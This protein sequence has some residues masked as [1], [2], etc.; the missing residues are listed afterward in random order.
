VN[1]GAWMLLGTFAFQPGQNHRVVLTDDGD[2]FVIADA[3]KLVRAPAAAPPAEEVVV[4]NAAAT[5]VGTWTATDYTLDGPFRDADWIYHAAGTGTA[6]ASFA[7]ALP[8]AGTYRVYA[9]WTQRA[10]RASNAPFTVHHAGGSTTVRVNQ[11]VNGG[12]WVLLGAFDMA[13]GQNHRVVLTDDANGFVIGDAVKFVLETNARAV[14]ADAVKI[15]GESVPAVDFAAMSSSVLREYVTLEGRPLALIENGQIQYVHPDHLGTPQKMTD[16]SGALVWD[17]V[18]RPF[19]EA[20]SITGSATNPQRFPGQVYDSET[21]FHY[22]YFRDYAPGLGR[23]VESDPIGLDGGLNTY[24]YVGGNPLNKTDPT[25]RYWKLIWEGCK[26]VWKWFRK[27][28]P[29]PKVD[30]LR[31]AKCK[32]AF[33]ACIGNTSI[34]EETCFAAYSTCIATKGPMIFPGYGAV[35]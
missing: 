28:K 19:G 20:E 13:P 8:A 15:V 17:A 3:V 26:A 6:S 9:R 35:K 1:G 10:N 32:Q 22:N 30:P 2:G 34:P 16:A 18:Y 23:Y 21:G 5:L 24:A 27:S 31:V 29:K 33:A 11:E 25:G 7:P 12:I 14:V 4:D